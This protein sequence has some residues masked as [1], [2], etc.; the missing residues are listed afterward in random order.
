MI[1]ANSE[2]I[3]SGLRSR[4]RKIS[5]AQDYLDRTQ[6]LFEQFGSPE[7]KASHAK[8]VELGR[9]LESDRNVLLVV[10]GEF[11]RG[12]SSLVNALMGIE[13]LRYA[14]E[15]TTA[16]N[17]FIRALPA[18]RSDKF[19]RIHF[20]D[21]RPPEELAW[22]DAATLERWST[23]LDTSHAEARRQVDHI[24]IFMSHPLLEQ[25]LV[26]IDTPGL[27]S[28]V[29]HHEAITR[30]AIA[31]AHIAIWVQSAQQLGGN[32]TEWAFLS[33]TIR[34]NF[35]KFITVVNMWDEILDSKDPQDIGKSEQQRAYDALDKVKG[36]FRK[37][38]HDQPADELALMTDAN[39]LMGVSAMWALSE[40]PAKRAR[41]GVPQLAAC[42]RDLFN[43][44]EA[45]DQV[46]R[47][48]LKQ[49]L[50]IQEQLAVSIVDE[51]GQL[52][53][54]ET[55]AE[56]QRDLELIDQEI[57][58]LD[59]EMRNATNESRQEHQNAARYMATQVEQKLVMPLANLKAEIEDELT[60]SYVESCVANKV[61]KIG[62]PD[63]L[64]RQFTAISA[65][66]E[67]TWREQKDRIGGSLEGLRAAYAE[68]MARHG[69]ELNSVLRSVD[70]KLAP[71]EVG[72]E[73]D[74]SRLE[75]YHSEAAELEQAIAEHEEEIEALQVEI[76][77]KRV[78]PMELETAKEALKRVQRRIDQLGP[79][80]PPRVSTRS[81]KV[82]SGGLYSSAKYQDVSYNDFSNVDAWKAQIQREEAALAQKEAQLQAIREEE[83]RRTGQII[84]DEAA[85][86][87]Y[88]KKLDQFARQKRE[89][90]RRHAEAQRDVVGD[91]WARLKRVTIGQLD[92]RI[93]YLKEHASEAIHD[94]YET[95]LELLADCVQEQYIEPLNA[96]R[97]QRE[98]VR[99]LIE[100]GREHVEKR[101]NLLTQGQSDLAELMN[102]TRQAGK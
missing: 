6:V 26:L 66:V 57:R 33:E 75:S 16:V 29:E 85:L 99:S 86:R 38:L 82:S 56:R 41:C 36:N 20:M 55:L 2:A 69:V 83:K 11:S 80:P 9:A 64:A 44:G 46:Y 100:Q 32:A 48:P 40:D 31:E 70:I 52:A 27:Q 43:S 1:E 25:G 91:T 79:E 35:S 58:N 78:D 74:L 28:L 17:T 81:E 22:T 49:M 67:Q 101:R 77:S 84:S 98:S 42:I 89:A 51:L 87:K 76:E 39:H 24:E 59:L 10:V 63:H 12:K 65:Q 88:Q 13:L 18:G 23:E 14:K 47:K 19:I 4:Q 7:L 102:M 68:R 72:F 62:L 37:Y 60:L 71:P 50:H 94:L 61:R 45:L 90:E 5:Q 95:Q 8:F 53:S 92:Q 30:K 73:L 93:A 21:Q 34:R 97:G 15:A 96:K 54:A 3:D